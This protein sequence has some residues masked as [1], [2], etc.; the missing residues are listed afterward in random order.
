VIDTATVAAQLAAAAQHAIA[1]ADD[2]LP[3]LPTDD[4][5][6]AAYDAHCQTGDARRIEAACDDWRAEQLARCCPG[7]VPDGT[8]PAC[9]WHDGEEAL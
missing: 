1:R 5:V 2:G 6:T 7:C 9:D 4:A 8:G 3:P